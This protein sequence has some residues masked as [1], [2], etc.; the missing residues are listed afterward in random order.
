VLHVPSRTLIVADLLFNFRHSSSRWT[1]LFARN[2]M[3][4]K[5]LSG[6]SPFFRSMIRDRAA[7]HQSLNEV[8]TWDFDRV[9]VG[10]GEPIATGGKERLRDIVSS[11]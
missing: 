2:V 6:M 11:V 10:H 8:L 1:K 4:L 9:I 3:R 5:N 7:F